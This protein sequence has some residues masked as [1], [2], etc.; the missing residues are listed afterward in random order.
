MLY[1][2]V[3]RPMLEEALNF[4]VTPLAL[5]WKATTL[6]NEMAHRSSAMSRRRNDGVNRPNDFL[7]RGRT[8]SSHCGRASRFRSPLLRA[9]R[10]S[11]ISRSQRS[12]FRRTSQLG[13]TRCHQRREL[14]SGSASDQPEPTWEPAADNARAQAGFRCFQLIARSAPR[15]RRNSTMSQS[16]AHRSSCC[17]I[18][19]AWPAV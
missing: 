8:S 17:A 15:S 12:G 16:E 4:H 2:A 13:L 19:A 6:N 18:G 7:D 3:S 9:R 11:K 14:S 10:A 1:R 5:V